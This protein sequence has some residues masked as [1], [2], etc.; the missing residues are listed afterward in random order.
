MFIGVF[1]ESLLPCFPP[2]YCGDSPQIQPHS[3]QNPPQFF[4]SFFAPEFAPESLTARRWVARDRIPPA[5]VD[6]RPGR[7]AGAAGGP[8][9]G[10]RGMLP[11]GIGSAVWCI[12]VWTPRK[13]AAYS[14]LVRALAVHLIAYGV[15]QVARAADL[16][17]RR[18]A[19]LP[20]GAK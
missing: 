7:G 8:S 19:I 9:Q 12:R 20:E 13:G 17:F 11:G 6:W 15:G 16:L 18:A 5:L 1:A 2:T 3:P 10:W 4:G 14:P